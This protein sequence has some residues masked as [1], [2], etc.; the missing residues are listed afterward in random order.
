MRM[1][2]SG[3]HTYKVA[4]PRE[5]LLLNKCRVTGYD[6]PHIHTQCYTVSLSPTYKPSVTRYH[7]A[8][9]TNPV[10]HGI[11]QPHLHTQCHT[12]SLSPTCK[13][14]VTGYHSAPPTNPV[15][16]GITQAHLYTQCHMV[17]LSPH[18][19]TQCHTASLSLT[20]KPSVTGY[21]SAPPTYPMS[22]GIT[23]PHPHTQCHTVSLSPTHIPSDTGY[24]G[25][26]E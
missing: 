22:H 15:S 18:L 5:L 7:S 13:P 1:A 26:A 24:V 10:S 4:Y 11:T 23:Q 3:V 12:V 6:L 8:S 2:L 17:S 21:H 14:S 16:H 25:G 20:Y 19:Q 9:P